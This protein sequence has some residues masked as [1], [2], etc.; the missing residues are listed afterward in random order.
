MEPVFAHSME[1]QRLQF[2]A[3]RVSIVLNKAAAFI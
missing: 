3:Y 1:L 2:N